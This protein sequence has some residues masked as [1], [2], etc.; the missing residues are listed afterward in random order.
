MSFINKDKKYKINDLKIG[1]SN[2][3]KRNKIN[4]NLILNCLYNEDSISKSI[5]ESENNFSNKQS[6]KNKRNI[7]INN[8]Y[9]SNTK[10][11]YYTENSKEEEEKNIGRVYG[12]I[13][14]VTFFKKSYP[15]KVRFDLKSNIFDNN[16]FSRLNKKPLTTK[17]K[18]SSSFE[19]EENLN[20]EILYIKDY[21]EKNYKIKTDRKN[22]SKYDIN[23]PNDH[24]K[25]INKKL[26]I[27]KLKDLIHEIEDEKKN[28]NGIRKNKIKDISHLLIG[29]TLK[30]KIPNI[31]N[32]ME[33]NKYLINDFKEN[34]SNIEYIKRSL[35]YQKISDNYEQSKSRQKTSNQNFF[36]NGLVPTNKDI[37][38]KIN[39][40]NNNSYNKTKKK[41][42]TNYMS[43]KSMYSTYL[44]KMKKISPK[45]FNEDN[46]NPSN[47]KE[48]EYSKR[49]SI[50]K[51][52]FS[53]NFI[54]Q[55]KNNLFDLSKKISSN[56]NLNLYYNTEEK[57]KEKPKKNNSY[58]KEQFTLEKPQ[59]NSQK[60]ITDIYSGTTFVRKGKTSLTNKQK[61][62]IHKKRLVLYDKLILS[63]NMY[64]EQKKYFNQYLMNKRISRSKNFSQQMS[65]LAREREKELELCNSNNDEVGRLPKLK[66]ESLL[67]EMKIKNLFKNSFN[68]MV[69]YREGDDDLDLD[70]L[71]KI[72]DSVKETEIKMFTSLKNEINPKYIKKKFNKTTIGKYHSTRGVYF[73]TK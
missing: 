73:G 45:K 39:N 18:N 11:R 22:Y 31:K 46:N 41:T 34:D 37:E 52:Y 5:T 58:L 4:K 68:P 29:R 62:K 69:N 33:L 28:I 38:I 54:M 2:K 59:R 65:N 27:S 14:K 47:N 61:R 25:T 43:P 1:L 7:S 30:E 63:N 70:N 10:K 24:S 13:E 71:K 21:N 55:Y 19:S 12:N 53:S 44:S 51:H 23:Y 42:R 40:N 9:N 48:N 36:Y 49:G 3:E 57:E 67:Y 56:K 50:S 66:E 6:K 15:N 60:K 35:K 16:T 17:R 26:L 20:N 32:R 64:N 8:R 72:K